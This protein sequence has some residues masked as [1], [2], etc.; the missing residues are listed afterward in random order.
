[1]VDL[2]DVLIAGA[3]DLSSLHIV[4]GDEFV[5]GVSCCSCH[6]FLLEVIIEENAGRPDWFPW[7]PESGTAVCPSS[8]SQ[9]NAKALL[10]GLAG[11]T[12]ISVASYAEQAPPPPTQP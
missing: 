3:I 5:V 12:A 9:M 4:A 11:A 6:G 1:M 8:S 7:E 2:T 10:L